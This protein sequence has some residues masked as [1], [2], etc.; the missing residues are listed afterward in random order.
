MNFRE[1]VH[2]FTDAVQT[3]NGDALAACFHDKGTYHDYIYGPFTGRRAIAAMLIQHF[4]GDA[5]DFNWE[6]YDLACTPG[7][8]DTEA[9]QG[10]TLGYARYRFSF[11]STMSDSA[12]RRVQVDGIGQFKI[13]DGLINEYFEVVNGGIAM[14][15][16][17]HAPE[18]MSRV[19]SRWSDRLLAQPGWD[20]HNR[21][22]D[23]Q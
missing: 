13:M 16:L 22:L 19:F 17:G 21:R 5:K 12:G 20:D 8:P 9:Q 14:S 1:L 4:H 23:Q 3:G 18:R 7:S 10:Q 11:V 2:Q 6:M 15:Q